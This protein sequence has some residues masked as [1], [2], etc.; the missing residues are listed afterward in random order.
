[1][2]N[3]MVRVNDVAKVLGG[4][5]TGGDAEITAVSTDTRTLKPGALF[6]AVDGERFQGSDFVADAER[7]GAAA[8]LTHQP[9]SSA[10]PGLVV[11]NTTAALGP[12]AGH[13][14]ARV[15][16]P[17]LGVAGSN[18][19]PFLPSPARF[20]SAPSISITLLASLCP[21][22]ACVIIIS[23]PSSRWG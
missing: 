4:E 7:A 17:V 11:E 8:V 19:K 21:C 16:I 22:L 10:L 5:L 15:G 2:D 14:R 23:L 18:G 13:W 3:A 6:V 12:L 20:T 9:H 1:M